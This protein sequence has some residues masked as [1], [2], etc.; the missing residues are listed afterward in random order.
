ML[1]KECAGYFK[2][3]RG[4]ERPMQLIRK[5]WKSYGRAAG[6]V[7]LKNATEQER[8]AL[9]KFMGVAYH[10]Q[11][12]EFT[13]AAWEKA[14]KESRYAQ[15][16]LKQLLEGY[17]QESM[18]TN[19]ALKQQEQEERAEFWR[20]LQGRGG[21]SETWGNIW[22]EKMAREAGAGSQIV[23]KEF[24]KNPAV[25][26]DQVLEIAAILEYLQNNK[27]APIRLAVLAARFTGNPH[28][29]DGNTLSGKLLIQA[30]SCM[31]E[32]YPQNAE[33]RMDLLYRVGILTDTLS[34]FTIGM[35][36]PLFLTDGSEHPGYGIMRER[37]EIVQLPLE[38]LSSI[39]SAGKSGQRIF[40]VENQMVFSHLCEQIKNHECGVICTSGQCRTASLV[41][42]DLLCR[43]GSKIYYSG[44]YD[45]EGLLIAD[46]LIRRG[47]GN[48]YLWHYDPETYRRYISAE[49]ISSERLQ[50]LG[51]LE[52]KGLQEI[53]VWMKNKKRAAYQEMYLEQLI[54]DIDSDAF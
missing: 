32:S 9:Q 20:A 23:L 17:F 47:K 12:V 24:K 35:G 45:P 38:S 25:I 21:D 16:T 54:Q 8:Q 31:F 39:A 42:L 13:L 5:K 2:S 50:S 22:I 52:N 53:A 48:I 1:Q 30:L 37:R 44:D 27:T 49:V 19:Q 28:A 34:S 15:V 11:E 46:K 51:K 7:V 40:V 18:E 41:L 33:E 26:K 14:L 43:S 3:D 29:F 36:I 10:E 4:Y 6:T